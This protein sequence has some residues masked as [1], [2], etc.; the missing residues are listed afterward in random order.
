[1]AGGVAL[2]EA[3]YGLGWSVCGGIGRLSILFLPWRAYVKLAVRF[4]RAREMFLLR[5]GGWHGAVGGCGAAGGMRC[6]GSVVGIWLVLV[7]P[8]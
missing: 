4:S 2:Q 7:S 1:M 5:C 3:R 8:Y 6:G